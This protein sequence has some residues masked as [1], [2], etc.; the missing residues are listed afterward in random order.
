MTI[1]RISVELTRKCNMNPLCRHCFRGE[2]QDVTIDNKSI[3]SLLNQTE[4]IGSLFFTGGE[5]TLAVDKMRYFLE[6]LYQRAI[7]LFK[8]EFISNG[9]LFNE[10]IVNVIKDYSDFVKLCRSVMDN[11]VDITKYVIIGISLDKYHYHENVA[12]ENLRKYKKALKGYAQVI[13]YG[14]GNVVR[15][16]GSAHSLSCAS[17][18]WDFEDAV[19][20]RIEI[21]DKNH[22]PRCPQ[23]KTYKLIKPEQIRICCDLYLS[24]K[25][26]LLTFALGDHGYYAVDYEKCIICNVNDSNIYDS[27][28]QYNEGKTDCISLIKR[29]T[30]KMRANPLRALC[31]TLELLLYD[32]DDSE[33]IVTDIPT[34]AITYEVL[35]FEI[36]PY[37]SL[38][39]K[40]IKDAESFDYNDF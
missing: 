5:P 7:P 9:L 36:A 10:E 16:E 2:P 39:D 4:I 30:Q 35:A 23:Y 17:S 28:I 22:K 29:Q 14:R 31:D 8:F 26:N 32:N 12:T 1:D 24:A 40:M 6:Q 21:L 18:S 25:G 3:D 37:P 27:I 20:K 34:G 33:E 19:H 15:K 38:L 13:K 11:D